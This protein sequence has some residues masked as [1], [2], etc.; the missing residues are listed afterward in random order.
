VTKIEPSDVKQWVKNYDKK[1]KKY[2]PI[3][4]ATAT[5]P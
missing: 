5:N 3:K 1:T 2:G 4:G